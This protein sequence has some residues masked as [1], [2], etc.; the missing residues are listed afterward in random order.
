MFKKVCEEDGSIGLIIIS[1]K[2]RLGEIEY[3]VLFLN[4]I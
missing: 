3:L 1:M 2:R 4:L